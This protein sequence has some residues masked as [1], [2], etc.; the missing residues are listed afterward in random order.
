MAKPEQAPQARAMREER[1]VTAM[2][3]A[4]SGLKD[5]NPTAAAFIAA[6]IGIATMGLLQFIAELNDAFNQSLAFSATLGPYSGKYLFSYLA[7]L[8]SWAILYPIT[9]AGRI[10]VGTS[11]IILAIL[12]VIGAVA[13]YPPFIGLFVSE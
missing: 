7:W 8:V 6:G 4:S 2:Y 12:V 10:T 3:P 5:R 1:E 13:L 9:R 11:L